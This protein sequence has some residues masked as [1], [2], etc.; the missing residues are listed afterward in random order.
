MFSIDHESVKQ[1]D[2]TV[3]NSRVLSGQRRLVT[4]GG[5]AALHCIALYNIP[6]FTAMH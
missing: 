6:Y 2:L 3:T 5:C 4:Q 1:N